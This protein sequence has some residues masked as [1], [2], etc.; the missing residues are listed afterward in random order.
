MRLLAAYRFFHNWKKFSTLW[1]TFAIICHHEE[2]GCGTEGAPA[3]L[4]GFEHFQAELARLVAQFEKNFEFYPNPTCSKARVRRRSRRR[5]FF[6]KAPEEVMKSHPHTLSAWLGLACLIPATL[7]FAVPA[8][9]NFASP[10]VISGFPLTATGS[11]IEA[12]VE[13]GEQLPAGRLFEYAVKSVWFSWT[14]PTSGLVRIDTFGSHEDGSWDSDYP[15]FRPTPSVWLGDTLETLIE[16][17]SGGTQQSRY[18]NA[19]S[20]TTYRIAVFGLGNDYYDEG[21]I[22]L[23]ITNDATAG[24]SGH[25]VDTNGIPLSGIMAR[26]LHTND[27]SWSDGVAWAFTDGAGN[28]TIRGLSNDSFR[29]RFS[30]TGYAPEL[31]DNVPDRYDPYATDMDATTPLTITNGETIAG[32]DATLAGSASVAGTVTG[33]GGIPL[34]GIEV[35]VYYGEDWYNPEAMTDENGEYLVENLPPDGYTILFAD[36]AGDHLDL[37]TNIV[38]DAGAL[39]ADL[40]VTMG[41]ASK[42]SGTVVADADAAPLEGIW[43]YA[44]QWNGSEWQD[45]GNALSD[46]DGYYLI[47]GLA[48]GT[49]RVQFQDWNGNYLSEIYDNV[50]SL[51]TGTDVVVAAETVVSNI[52]ASLTQASSIAGTVTEPDGTTPLAYLQVEAYRW[53]GADWVSF[54]STY[55][56]SD[57][58]YNLNGLNAGTYR[59]WFYGDNYLYAPEAYDNAATLAA[60]TDLV[61]D[62]ADSLTGINAALAL[63]NPPEPPILTLIREDTTNT[64]QVTY[65]GTIG[66]NYVVQ[67]AQSLTNDW[68]DVGEAGACLGTPDTLYIPRPENPVFLRLRML[69]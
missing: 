11:N 38:L 30:G 3:D 54:R 64:I 53:D 37:S 4:V 27:Y 47:G 42:I 22:V 66:R 7:A 23:N 43:V 18:L 50:A 59:I 68:A 29:I 58:T 48:A 67:Q 32:I 52:N 12:T 55:T 26:A 24:I 5:R 61:L 41:V 56:G 57:G 40:D 14:A 62:V 1:K 10:A 35:W 44:D 21:Q 45:M 46:A 28:Y 36:P 49:Y 51:D 60:G 33:P 17:Q 8:N 20:G 13:S 16:V 25:I 9:D 34:E 19:V 65:S 63:L 69:P 2:E 6:K 39:L 31:Y 15:L